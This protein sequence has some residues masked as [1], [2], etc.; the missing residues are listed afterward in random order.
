MWCCSKCDFTL[1]KWY[2]LPSLWLSLTRVCNSQ[3]TSNGIKNVTLTLPGK[4]KQRVEGL[5][6]SVEPQNKLCVQRLL[7][8][9]FSSFSPP[10]DSH[11]STS[12]GPLLFVR[13]LPLA[14][15]R[16]SDLRHVFQTVALSERS[17]LLSCLSASTSPRLLYFLL[18]VYFISLLPSSS[19][20]LLS[21]FYLLCDL[22]VVYSLVIFLR[23]VPVLGPPV[24][25]FLS[26]LATW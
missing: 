3:H 16:P 19:Y 26:P 24:F 25:P 22:S 8:P 14:A 15:Y 12:S 10:S 20:L 7:V 9:S 13:P 17:Q 2:F 23:T 1:N 6:W 4:T 21:T 5:V 18:F 11:V